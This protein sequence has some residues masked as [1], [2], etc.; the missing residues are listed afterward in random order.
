M[1]VVWFTFN[2]MEVLEIIFKKH[3][4]WCDIVESFGVNPD[5]SEDIVM[6]MYIKIDRLVKSGTDIMYNEQE[7]NYYYVYR[8]LQTLFLDL[9]RKEKKVKKELKSLKLKGKNVIM[10]TDEVDQAS[11]TNESRTKINSLIDM[12]DFDVI[13]VKYYC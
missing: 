10:V 8:T 11:H 5:T 6:E 3:Q 13:V 4:D 1:S 2:G 7:V 12:I 9:K